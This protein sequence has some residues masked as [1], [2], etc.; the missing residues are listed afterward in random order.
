MKVL[1]LNH[2]G[3]VGAGDMCGSLTRALDLSLQ[4]D[5]P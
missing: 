5:V 3:M 1:G 2:W 4:P